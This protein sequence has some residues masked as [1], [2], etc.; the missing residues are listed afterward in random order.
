MDGHNIDEEHIVEQIPARL[1]QAQAYCQVA[2][3]K[4]R[5]ITIQQVHF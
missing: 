2:K 4:I 5:K 1:F 3:K